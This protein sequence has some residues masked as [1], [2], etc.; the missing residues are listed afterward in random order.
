MVTVIIATLNEAEWISRS[1]ESAFAAGAAEVIV[2]DGG[3]TD[4]TVTLARAAG[5]RVI[6]ADAMRSRQMNR[7]AEAATGDALI[8]LHGDTLL[9]PGAAAAVEAALAS[10]ATFGGFR[11]AFIER[12][13]KLRLA[14][15][16]INIRTAITRAPW[17]DQAQFVRRGSFKG[18]REIP[19]MEDYDLAMTMRRSGTSR[20]LPLKVRTSGRRFLR[21]GLLRT[22]ATNW[23]IIALYHRG[24]DVEELARLYRR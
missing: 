13:W 24:S 1:V 18:F 7:G 12:S 11:I 15:A 10:G 21:K 14:A 23:R 2:A 17:G 9:P 20:V 3:S 16:L 22:A 8:F 5:A 19:I 6:G 4:E